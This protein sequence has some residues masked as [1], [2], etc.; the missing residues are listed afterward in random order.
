MRWLLLWILMTLLAVLLA[1]LRIG[2]IVMYSVA[3]YSL[4]VVCM[5]ISLLERIKKAERFLQSDISSHVKTWNRIDELNERHANILAS[6][7]G[8]VTNLERNDE[9][10]IELRSMLIKLRKQ[11][12]M[13]N[14]QFISLTQKILSCF[15]PLLTCLKELEDSGSILDIRNKLASL[16]NQHA[17]MYERMLD[18]IRSTSKIDERVLALA[19]DHQKTHSYLEEDHD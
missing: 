3:A 6:L 19:K 9:T 10:I 7:D 4:L 1:M 11:N 13:F 17:S 2:N 5:L 14:E 18:I 15:Q 16:K 8:I 12:E